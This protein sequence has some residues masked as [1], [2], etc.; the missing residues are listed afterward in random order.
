MTGALAWHTVPRLPGH[1][2]GGQPVVCGAHSTGM[3]RTP[4]VFPGLKEGLWRSPRV[5]RL[6]AERRETI[7]WHGVVVVARLC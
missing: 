6:H 4:A 3:E 2:L 7:G 1:G 5:Q